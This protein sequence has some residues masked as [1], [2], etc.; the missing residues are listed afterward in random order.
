M[1]RLPLNPGNKGFFLTG[2]TRFKGLQRGHPFFV[3]ALHK[4]FERL[5]FDASRVAVRKMA[6]P[7]VIKVLTGMSKASLL[8]LS[9]KLR[10]FTEVRSS[11]HPQSRPRQ[12]YW[13]IS[14]NFVSSGT[15]SI[16]QGERLGQRAFILDTGSPTDF[17]FKFEFHIVVYQYL[18]HENGFVKGSGPW[19]SLGQGY[20][21]FETFIHENWKKYVPDYL[22]YILTGNILE[23]PPRED[24]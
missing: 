21:A 2:D 20:F 3:K 17:K 24:V 18:L 14:G 4:N 10:I 11:I 7:E 1:S 9:R 13:D 12:G 15:Q 5:W 8:P 22:H 16:A 23:L 6:T 19:N